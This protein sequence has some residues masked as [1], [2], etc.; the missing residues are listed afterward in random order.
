MA[1]V[2]REMGFEPSKDFNFRLMFFSGEAGAGEPNVKKKLLETWNALSIDCGSTSE[3][4]PWY[5]NCECAERTGMHL[6]QDIVYAEVIDPKTNELVDYGEEG[7]LVYTHMGRES[8]PMIRFWSN[9][10]AKW[11]YEGCPCGR[12]YPTLP[13]GIYGRYDDMFKIRGVGVWTTGVENIL[14]GIKGFGYEFRCVVDTSREMESLEVAAEYSEDI[15][16]KAKQDPRVLDELKSEME[17]ELRLGLGVGC[18][19]TLQPPK[20]LPRSDI[21]KR[22]RIVFKESKT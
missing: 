7:V 22:S 3:M 6:W 1:E 21:H 16:V 18:N 9:D 11:A 19:V 8:H 4:A 15:M 14:R 17:R 13:R 5:S 2:A 12:T 20:S 10:I